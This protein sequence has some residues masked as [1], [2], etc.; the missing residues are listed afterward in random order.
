MENRGTFFKDLMGGQRRHPSPDPFAAG[1]MFPDKSRN[2]QTWASMCW[3]TKSGKGR[4]AE[5]VTALG[6]ISIF[7]G[8]FVK[9]VAVEWTSMTYSCQ[10]NTT[11]DKSLS[12]S[13][14]P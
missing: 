3:R 5:N 12:V 6:L 2:T 13:Y 4:C 8:N 11:T 10:I 1:A 7:G 9:I 14:K